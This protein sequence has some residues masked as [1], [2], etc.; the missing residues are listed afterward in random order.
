[1]SKLVNSKVDEYYVYNFVS[2]LL[3]LSMSKGWLP[4]YKRNIRVVT[5]CLWKRT[6]RPN[7]CNIG[8]IDIGNTWYET[9]ES[10]VTVQSELRGLRGDVFDRSFSRQEYEHYFEPFQSTRSSIVKRPS[11]FTIHDTIMWTITKRVKCSRNWSR[12]IW[13]G[14]RCVSATINETLV[15]FVA[16]WDIYCKLLFDIKGTVINVE[17]H[18]G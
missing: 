5:L 13:N 12:K 10:S 17:W 14:K 2:N 8:W 15:L 6:W 3:T 11:L 18:D 16:V 4:K 1:M 9:R 7:S